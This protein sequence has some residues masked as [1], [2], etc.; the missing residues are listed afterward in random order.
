MRFWDSSALVTLFVAQPSSAEVRAI[1]AEDDQVLAWELTD[2]EL[3]SALCRLEQDQV[4]TIVALQ[5]AV[6]RIEEFWTSVHIVTLNPPVKERAKRLLGVHALG[7]AD[8]LQL[9]AALTAVGERPHG[10]AFVCLDQ[11]LGEAARREGFTV[12]P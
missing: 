6:A 12:V 10:W 2:V 8:S 7:A 1:Y 3:R 11:R 5:K 9:G 4:L